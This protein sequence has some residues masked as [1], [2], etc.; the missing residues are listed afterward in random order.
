MKEEYKPNHEEIE[1]GEEIMTDKQKEQSAMAEEI[2]NRGE[3]FGKR[4]R[5]ATEDGDKEIT[6]NMDDMSRLLNDLKFY[7]ESFRR[8]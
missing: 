1:R 6:I 8:S 5:K 3:E 7:A 2:W 4:F